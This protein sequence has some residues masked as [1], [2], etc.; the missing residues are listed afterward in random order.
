MIPPPAD[1]LGVLASLC[2]LL[3]HTV[4]GIASLLVL[5]PGSPVIH[6]IFQRAHFL[7]SHR[8]EW[9]LM[10]ATWTMASLSLFGFFWAIGSRLENRPE[11]LMRAI[12]IVML[13]ALGVDVSAQVMYA[14]LAPALATDLVQA[15]APDRILAAARLVWCERLPG[16]LSGG[17]ANSL[18]S[19]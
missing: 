15:A 14:T 5:I 7:S 13:I 11:R 6:D 8:F 12:A 9:T 18:Y 2:C 16:L 4:A 19:R 17:V 3:L 10:W 1:P